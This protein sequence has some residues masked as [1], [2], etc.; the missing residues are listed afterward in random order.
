M[1]LTK[2]RAVLFTWLVVEVEEE[3]CTGSQ[4]WEGCMTGREEEVCKPEV[5][6]PASTLGLSS[7]A[8]GRREGESPGNCWRS[9]AV[10]LVDLGS[11]RISG[12]STALARSFVK[13]LD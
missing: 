9:A 4:A 8:S 1:T 2:V 7:S 12:L 11:I 6:N 5:R 3:A 13:T 10:C